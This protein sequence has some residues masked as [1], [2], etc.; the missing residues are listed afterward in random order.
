MNTHGN[1]MPPEKTA[2]EK[3][4]D[5]FSHLL[6]LGTWIAVLFAAVMLIIA[7]VSSS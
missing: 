4:Q 5:R 2:E 6:V 7:L 1:S 3:A